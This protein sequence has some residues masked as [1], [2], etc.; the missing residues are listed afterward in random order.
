[1]GDLEFEDHGETA[2]MHLRMGHASHIWTIMIQRRIAWKR[3]DSY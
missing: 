2:L 3:G 1:M